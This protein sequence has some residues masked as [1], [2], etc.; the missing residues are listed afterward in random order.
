ME[1]RKTFS[2]SKAKVKVKCY[3]KLTKDLYHSH[4]FL[5]D[6]KPSKENIV[7]SENVFL[8]FACFAINNVD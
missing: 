5:R 6:L 1:Q 8:V 3:L 7:N 4:A 2:T